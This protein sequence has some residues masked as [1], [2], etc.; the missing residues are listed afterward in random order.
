VGLTSL[1]KAGGRIP[2]GPVGID[3]KRCLGEYAESFYRVFQCEMRW[4]LI[5]GVLGFSGLFC[6]GFSSSLLLFFSVLVFEFTYFFPLMLIA[7]NL[8]L[9][10][11]RVTSVTVQMKRYIRFTRLSGVQPPA[12]AVA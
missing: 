4:N 6:S 5:G 7:I 12:D 11:K 9:L 2:Q 10:D 8:P 3:G 1:A